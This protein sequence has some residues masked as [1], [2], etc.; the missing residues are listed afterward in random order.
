MTVTVQNSMIKN[1]NNHA[2]I[3]LAQG[4]NKLSTTDIQ[5]FLSVNKIR[6]YQL[7]VYN[8]SITLLQLYERKSYILS[9]Y[10]QIYQLYFTY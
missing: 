6:P 3:S 8:Y 2:G 10:Y 9:I 7:K 5:S 4:K 1:S